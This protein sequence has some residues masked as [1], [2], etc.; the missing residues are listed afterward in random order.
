MRR[1][2]TEQQQNSREERMT[3]MAEAMQLLLEAGALRGMSPTALLL[4][5]AVTHVA[6]NP[7]DAQRLYQAVDAAIRRLPI[8]KV[9]DANG[10]KVLD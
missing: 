6:H 10:Q 2:L 3:Q 9:L 8:T 1:V 4:S 7:L 5:Y